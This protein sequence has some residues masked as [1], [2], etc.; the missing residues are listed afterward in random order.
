MGATGICLAGS[1]LAMLPAAAA[2]E[3]DHPIDGHVQQI[4]RLVLLPDATCAPPHPLCRYQL[5]GSF[6]EA[7]GYLGSGRAGGRVFL[8]H[9]AADPVT[10]CIPA[11]GILKLHVGADD[12]RGALAAGSA[13]CPGRGAP[14][15]LHEDFTVDVTGGVG[16][17]A[18]ITGGEYRWSGHLK[19]TPRST[20]MTGTASIHGS[21]S[22][23]P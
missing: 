18:D 6:T 21:I 10:G 14:G 22:T 19:P 13:V 12:V 16:A 23:T 17:Y 7:S 9:G 3:T 1:A 8:D 2:A 5:S 11:T 20:T 15:S 4:L